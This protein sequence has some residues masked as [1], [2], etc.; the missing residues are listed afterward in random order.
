MREYGAAKK[1]FLRAKTNSSYSSSRRR[2]LDY[3][4]MD[5]NRSPERYVT[6]NVYHKGNDDVEL[7]HL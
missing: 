7:L 1:Q 5:E 2:E 3:V 4:S 6:I